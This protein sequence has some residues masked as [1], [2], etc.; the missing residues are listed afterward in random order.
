MMG[1]FPGCLWPNSSGPL[2]ANTVLQCIQPLY[3]VLASFYSSGSNTRAILWWQFPGRSQVHSR[4]CSLDVPWMFPGCF[5]DIPGRF[6]G[7]SREVPR[8]ILC[9]LQSVV[10]ILVLFG[11]L[12]I[13][14]QDAR[15]FPGDWGTWYIMWCS[16]IPNCYSDCRFPRRFSLEQSNERIESC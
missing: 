16:T 6:P 4:G 10:K 5:Q 7:H 8:L 1:A 14:N 13:A 3:Q 15:F 9:N 2:G 12:I 11:K